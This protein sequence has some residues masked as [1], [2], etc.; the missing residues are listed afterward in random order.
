MVEV[1]ETVSPM[2]Y[3]KIQDIMGVKQQLEIM[4]RWQLESIDIIKQMT[5]A[6][7]WYMNIEQ[8]PDKTTTLTVAPLVDNPL[9][10]KEGVISLIQNLFKIV[11]KNTFLSNLKEK[12]ALAILVDHMIAILDDLIINFDYY[13]IDDLGTLE[14]IRSTV[15][16][17]SEI[18]LSRGREGVTLNYLK[19]IQHLVERI[20]VREGEKIV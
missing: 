3:Q 2:S 11:N 12:E 16:N 8:K 13:A 5:E 14:K 10:N 6:L 7:G 17:M 1:S 9:L 18:A 19:T 15:E 20:G 4:S